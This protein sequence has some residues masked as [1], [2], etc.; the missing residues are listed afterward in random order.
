MK[1]NVHSMMLAAAFA[2]FATTAEADISYTLDNQPSSTWVGGDSGKPNNWD[3]PAN[4]SDN[5]VPVQDTWRNVHF[6]LSSATTVDYGSKYAADKD[7]G[8]FSIVVDAT[9][10]PLTITQSDVPLRW[11][12]SGSSGVARTSFVNLSPSHAVFDIEVIMYGY[13]DYNSGIHPGAEFNRTFS[14]IAGN[15]LFVFFAGDSE[16]AND[17]INTTVFRA[18]MTS[19]KPISIEQNHIVKLNGSSASMTA[20]GNDIAVAGTLQV[21]GGSVTCANLSVAA[22]GT[23]GGSGTINAAVSATSGAILDFS[24][25]TALTFAGTTD[26]TGFTIAASDLNPAETYV[27]ARGTTSLPTVPAALQADGWTVKAVGWNVV[28]NNSLVPETNATYNLEELDFSWMSSGW[29]QAV[30]NHSIFYG[31]PIRLWNGTEW[32]QYA[33]GI[34]VQ[35][36][37]HFYIKLDGKGVSFSSTVGL[38]KSAFGD[39]NEPD[40]GR[41]GSKVVKFAVRDVVNDVTLAESSWLGTQSAAETLVADVRGVEL[42]E[43][44]VYPDPNNGDGWQHVDWAEPTLVMKGDAV[45]VTKGT[46]GKNHWTGKGSNDYWATAANWEFGTPVASATAV[47]DAS[48]TVRIGE[49]EQGNP[50]PGNASVSNLIVNAG[51]VLT[52]RPVSPEFWDA[53][54]L[55]LQELNGNGKVQLAKVGLK[56][57]YDT[58]DTCIFSVAEIEAL[59][60]TRWNNE[61]DS[62]IDGDT[63]DGKQLEV[64]SDV[65]CTG[66][67]TCRGNTTFSGDVVLYR[68]LSLHG[69]VV[70]AVTWAGGIIDND[71]ENSGTIKELRIVSGVYDYAAHSSEIYPLILDGGDIDIGNG[72][73][74]PAGGLSLAVVSG[75][76]IRYA[77]SD[78]D[79][80]TGDVPDFPEHLS[81]ANEADLSSVVCILRNATGDAH[82][83]YAIKAT[84]TGYAF[85][86]AAPIGTVRWIGGVD[87]KWETPGNWI[88][89]A[90]PT[91]GQSV[92]FTS[93]ANIKIVGGTTLPA[94]STMTIGQYARVRL[95]TS[96][97]WGWDNGPILPFEKIVGAG[98]LQLKHASLKA[99]A[100]T[101]IVECAKLEILSHANND[102]GRSVILFGG[103]GG[104]PMII[105]SDISGVG[106]LKIRDVVAFSGDNSGFA[107]VVD[108]TSVGSYANA[109]RYIDSPKSTFANASQF[110]FYGRLFINF[111]EGVASL[112]NVLLAESWGASLVM[113]HGANVTLQVSEGIINDSH[114][115]D[116]YE[117][118][119]RDLGVGD[120]DCFSS[121]DPSSGITKGCVGLTVEK[122]GAGTLVYGLTKMH[123]LVVS[124]GR[125]EFTG[126]NN[127]G[128][129]AAVNVLVKA[130]ASIG[131]AA[132]FSHENPAWT[133]GGDVAIRHNVLFEE[134][135]AVKQ[136]FVA[137]TASDEVTGEETTTYSMDKLTIERVVDVTGVRFGVTNPDDLPPVTGELAYDRQMR[138]TIFSANSLVGDIST[139]NDGYA[140]NGSG[141]RSKWLCHAKKNAANEVEFYPFVNKG[142]AIF[143][144]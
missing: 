10:A 95:E 121:F 94:I 109:G 136:R 43:L 50:K 73:S 100:S 107:G 27:V 17:D 112:G 119:T 98:T 51:A 105:R 5:T 57:N 18:A 86:A 110:K 26:L 137:T 122:V 32:T 89:G 114:N 41:C 102:T 45:P 91:A 143:L 99:S 28:L 52:I 64:N 12:A 93:S 96:D 60:V 76:S 106:Y 138:F 80:E 30:A 78:V 34:G 16:A 125:V 90:V 111:T 56:A 71:S 74:L 58:R 75:G 33:R 133:L 40:A 29:S 116:G 67:L 82:R 92:E 35:A 101:S 53:P 62:W 85:E 38:D 54:V 118:W 130:G 142:F 47:F 70:E 66:W 15:P 128:D 25:K 61:I 44:A 36:E 88:Y 108:F 9:S 97:E 46:D 84:E 120:Y 104:G 1:A 65:I 124:E 83:I 79:F 134:G 72:S 131:S 4:W 42:I 129:D 23:L 117:V 7:N 123:S 37:S 132:A 2:A 87:E 24:A 55:T 141:W 140:P 59:A 69:V 81:F 11:Y 113:K 8:S 6:N 48:A 14:F 22:G 144:R 19:G 39:G 13:R 115:G 49:T 68:K 3:V 127:G 20:S 63:R 21:L 139:E 31:Q 126:E 135:A 77:I 103:N